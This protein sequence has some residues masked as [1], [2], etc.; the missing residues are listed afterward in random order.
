MAAAAPGDSRVSVVVVT[1]DRRDSL[2]AA[3][4]RL[5]ALPERPRVVVVDNGSRDGSADAVRDAHPQFEVVALGHDRAAAA[6]TIG[7]R[8]AR[9]SYVAFSDD[10]SWWAPGSLSRAADVLDRYP[11]LALVAGRVL[12]G[13]EERED[14]F[15]RTLE[16]SPL[17]SDV[18]LP[19]PSV[20]GFIACATV[21]R[22]EPFLAAGGF[23]RRLALA[24]EEALLAFD[25][26]D[27]GWKLAYVRDVV[28]HHHPS[29]KRDRA[30]RRRDEVRNAFATAWLRR[31][32]PSAARETAA[33]ARASLTD[34][35][36]RRGLCRG[37]LDLHW[38][39]RERRVL[40]PDVEAAL[41]ALGH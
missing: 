35:E 37:V 38:V 8:R 9:T 28:A 2:L 19:G 14:A 31:P 3:L 24:G 6:R 32:G 12:V 5:S 16:K 17:T 29:P 41:R 4:A 40:R 11:L 36:A 10:D 1:R 18:A 21:V 33:L 22:R 34:R 15:S 27:R 7:A 30:R 23:H 13:A 25:L 26:A 20:L 39:L